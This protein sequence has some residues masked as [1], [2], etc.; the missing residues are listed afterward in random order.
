MTETRRY[1]IGRIEG[2]SLSGARDQVD[3]RYC[4]NTVSGI[5][6]LIL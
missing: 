3:Q 1:V 6:A 4:E 5:A 2:P